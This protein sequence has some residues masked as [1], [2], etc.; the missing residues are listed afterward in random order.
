[1]TIIGTERLRSGENQLLVFD[2]TFKDP[3]QVLELVGHEFEVRSPERTIK[4]Y[5][6]GSYLRK[7]K[8]FEV[9]R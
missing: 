1:M 7:F 3:P 5:R 8:E 4:H 9:L 2:P 6:R